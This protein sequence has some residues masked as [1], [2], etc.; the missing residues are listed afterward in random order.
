MGKWFRRGSMGKVERRSDI[1]RRRYLS[2]RS[3][4][5]YP[6]RPPDQHALSTGSRG[7]YPMRRIWNFRC[8][9]PVSG[10][11]KLALVRISLNTSFNLAPVAPCKAM[12]A[13]L[14]GWLSYEATSGPRWTLEKSVLDN[15]FSHV[16]LGRWSQKTSSSTGLVICSCS[17]SP[18]HCCRGDHRD[19]CREISDGDAGFPNLTEI[20]LRNRLLYITSQREL[21]RCHIFAL[22]WATPQLLDSLPGNLSYCLHLL[23]G[24]VDIISLPIDQRRR[25]A[26]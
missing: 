18:K 10:D 13:F 21:L 11:L 14:S 25:L 8:I 16:G 5:R 1:L 19:D 15:G 6:L 2:A 7:H 3:S 22:M 17:W 23:I 4:G 26:A 20:C 12:G 9:D 24:L